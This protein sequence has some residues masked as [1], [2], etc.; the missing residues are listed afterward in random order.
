MAYC[1]YIRLYYH[2]IGHNIDIVPDN[3]FGCFVAVEL[4]V[5]ELGY[6]MVSKHRAGY[7]IHLHLAELVVAVF[8]VV[9]GLVVQLALRQL[10]WVFFSAAYK[11]HHYPA[12]YFQI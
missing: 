8:A 7:N 5:V 6:N 12:R 2:H 11:P 4:G 10:C 3:D 9:L 1:P